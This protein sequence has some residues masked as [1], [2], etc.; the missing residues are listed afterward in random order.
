MRYEICYT[1]HNEK[2]TIK[3]TYCLCI[4]CKRTKYCVDKCLRG[5]K[6]SFLD[7]TVLCYFVIKVIQVLS[8]AP[9]C[10]GEG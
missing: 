8:V 4:L 10:L 9:L 3:N 5:K 7:V 6:I 1:I 2:T